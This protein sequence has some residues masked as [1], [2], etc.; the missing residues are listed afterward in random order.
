MS[1]PQPMND[2]TG[3][4]VALPSMYCAYCGRMLDEAKSYRPLRIA[5]YHDT[6]GIICPN[7]GMKFS[8][9]EFFKPIWKDA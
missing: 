5:Y 6:D 4:A 7:A 1:D 8:G 3:F 2:G 9:A